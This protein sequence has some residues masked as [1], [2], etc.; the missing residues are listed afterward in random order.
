MRG[1]GLADGFGQFL[2]LE[3][4]A[5]EVPEA[6]AKVFA[7]ALHLA[8]GHF[9]VWHH[10]VG[11]FF[12]RHLRGVDLQGDAGEVLRQRVMQFHGEAGAFLHLQV[13]DVVRGLLLKQCAAAP[14][15]E[16]VQ[17]AVPDEDAAQDDKQCADDDGKPQGRPPW[18]TRQDSQVI[19]G[20]HDERHAGNAR[21]RR[22]RAPV[23]RL[24]EAY[25][26]DL[27]DTVLGDI[28]EG[29]WTCF[30]IDGDDDFAAV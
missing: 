2:F 9:Q 26:G 18:R 27:D 1:D 19:R 7:A 3:R 11:V 13:G 28:V 5:P 22:V 20:A 8:A 15:Y 30:G 10:R 14:F 16:T 6:V 23:L 12:R 4:A 17:H 21:K 24:H 29:G 25:A